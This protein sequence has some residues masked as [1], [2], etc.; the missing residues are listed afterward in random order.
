MAA[1]Q[2]VKKYLSPKPGI[3]RD[4]TLFDSENYID[5]LW[6]RF[7]RNKPRKI[8]GYKMAL[9]GTTAIMRAISVAP[10]SL[11]ADLAVT[12]GDTIENQNIVF[13][14]R[15]ASFTMTTIDQN[16]NTTPEVNRTPMSLP[17]SVNNTWDI[18]YYT[19]AEEMSAPTNYVLA[20]LNPNNNN[21]NGNVE[22]AV[23]YGITNDPTLL[24]ELNANAVASGGV[25]VVNDYVV[26]YGNEGV[27]RWS[28]P[29]DLTNWPDVNFQ[30]ITNSKLLKAYVTRGG[31][32]PTALFWSTNALIRAAHDVAEELWNIDVIEDT[33]SVLGANT[34]VKYNS[35]FYWVGTDQFYY[36]NGVVQELENTLSK[37]T[38]FKDLN[39]NQRTKAWGMV[40]PLWNEIWWTVPTGNSTECDHT[41]IYNYKV[42]TWYDT[43]LN[44]SC[45]F[46]PILFKYPLMASSVTV[47]DLSHN[48]PPGEPPAQVYSL[49]A[50]EFGT[51]QVMFQQNLA[52]LSYFETNITTLFENS[53]TDD[54]Q[55]RT[56]RIEPDFVRTGQLQIEVRGWAFAAS[57]PI[58]SDIL[59]FNEGDS[60]VD[61]SFMSRLSSYK[62]SSNQAGGD[63][64][65]G[66]IILDFVPGDQRPGS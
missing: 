17:V 34:V 29:T 58:T 6:V 5:G 59:L 18:D 38:F 11:T 28:D 44:R 1:T 2:Y 42:N 63:Y 36:Y 23:Y 7:Y 43:P 37:Q 15:A 30:A 53:P 4:G 61:S 33:I 25:I 3:D 12:L 26:V 51:D 47:A 52:I 13:I 27:I 50:H 55:V 21:I 46:P 9:A 65:A 8:G 31:G 10:L 40:I 45:G 14:G 35:V 54:Y 57:I 60:K 62:F 56:R 39:L 16:L 22:G 48:P 66:K 20:H 19:Q 64:Q 24:T 49:W 41:Y 32:T